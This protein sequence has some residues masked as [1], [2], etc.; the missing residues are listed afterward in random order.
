M[1]PQQRNRAIAGLER[2]AQHYQDCLRAGHS[3]QGVVT[4]WQREL[5]KTRA[6]IACLKDDRRRGPW[7]EYLEEA[8]R[9]Q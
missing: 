7:T 4:R 9:E 2:R 5:I 8:R 1:N 3:N 6:L